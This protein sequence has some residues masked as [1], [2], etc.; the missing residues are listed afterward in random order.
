MREHP[1]VVRDLLEAEV[2]TIRFM[3]QHP[4]DAR[5][6]AS[7]ELVRVG[8]PRMPADVL[9]SAWDRISFTWAVAPF[10]FDRLTREAH[11]L[12]MLDDAPTNVAGMFRLDALNGVL[13]DDGLPRVPEP[14]TA[15]VS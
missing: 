3:N 9:A 15:E 2:Q 4:D 12:G 8:G 6:I 14:S 1:D 7:G 11:A 13:D 10:T 5:T